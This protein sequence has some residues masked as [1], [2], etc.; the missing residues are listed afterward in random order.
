MA[1]RER[2]VIKMAALVVVCACLV[3]AATALLYAVN[4]IQPETYMV[5]TFI[6]V[7]IPLYVL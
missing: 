5:R 4:S 3:A 1:S 2:H 6:H 7:S